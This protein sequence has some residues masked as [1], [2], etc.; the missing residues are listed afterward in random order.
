ML[1]NE[2]L[3]EITHLENVISTIT[4]KRILPYELRKGIKKE[5]EDLRSNNHSKE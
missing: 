5:M 2:Y 3:K 1:E 4:G